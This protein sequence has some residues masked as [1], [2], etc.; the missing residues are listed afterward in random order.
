MA[1]AQTKLL[2]QLSSNSNPY[3]DPLRCLPWE[4]LSQEGWWLPESAVSLYG[5]AEYQALP[6][7][8]RQRL[9]Q[10][11]FVA[12]IQAGLWLEAVF[13]ERLSRHL[14]HATGAEHAYCL[15]EIREEAGHSLM[16]LTLM[17]KSGVRTPAA[18]HRPPFLG[19]WLGR[20]APFNGLLFWLAVVVG[21][22][23]SDKMNRHIRTR[24]Q[25]EVHPLIRE[26]CTLHVMDEARHIAYTR[27]AL[28]AVLAKAGPARKRLLSPVLNR[29]VSQFARLFYLPHA[30]VYELAGLAPGSRWRELARRNPERRAFIRHCLSPTLHLLEEHGFRSRL[31]C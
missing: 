3:R 18:W 11:E 26:M 8:V 7:S 22:E 25:G 20:R 9:S 15:H 17:D 1:H 27:S 21:E 10:H 12:F 4:S 23:A 13:M 2:E 19:R 6:Q 31:T 24:P 14:H 30:G 5:L 16:F 28:D 29:L